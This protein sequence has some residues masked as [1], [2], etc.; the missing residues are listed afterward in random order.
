M[1][2]RRSFL[3]TLPTTFFVLLFGLSA[4]F[5][6]LTSYDPTLLGDTPLAA[7]VSIGLFLAA[8]YLMR[9]QGLAQ[10]ISLILIALCVGLAILF[11][12]Q[13]RYQEYPEMAGVIQRLGDATTLLPNLGLGYLHPNAV[14]TVLEVALP[15]ALA[16]TLSIRRTTLR[17]VCA[18]VVLLFLYAI[19]LTYSRGAYI[20]LGGAIV[21]LVLKRLARPV[22]WVVMFALALIAIGGVIALYNV[23]PAE[24]LPIL[25]RPVDAR[26]TLYHNSLYLAQD[27]AFSGIGLGS[28]FGN[29]YSRYSLLIQ[30]VFLTY[31]HNLLLSVWLNQGLLGL[32]AFL[33]IIITFYSYVAHIIGRGRPGVLFHGLWL[34]VTATLVHGLFDARQYTE[35]VWVMPVLFIALGLTIAYGQLT[36]AEDADVLSFRQ[37]I[38]LP[39]G[40]AAA[41]IAVLVVLLVIFRAPITAAWLTNQG[42]LRETRAEFT[43]DLNDDER[44]SL[45]D[46]A[47]AGYQD[48]L[49]TDPE[50]APANRR[51]GNLLVGRESFDE[52]VPL[53]ERAY[54]HEPTNPAAIKG[55]GLAYVWVGRTAEAAE[56]LKRLPNVQDMANELYTWGYFRS[57]G[58][59]QKPLL[60]AYAW[61]TAEMMGGAGNVD[62]WMQIGGFYEE[63]DAL[64][65][66]RA[67]YE[68]VIE[69]DPNNEAAQAALDNL[70]DS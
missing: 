13:F 23:N 26:L 21:V 64:D 3:P 20:G 36:P 24:P 53:L 31:S 10:A 69:L 38:R 43:P 16:F 28:T 66:A 63:A 42:A 67:A 19:F 6:M 34:G 56:L 18:L 14:A 11:I 9:T 33:G 47:A 65:R 54:A 35:S 12:G 41:T 55:L 58:E 48:A 8:A 17:L 4:Y 27:Y 62:V 70:N 39:L 52:A 30:P 15:L 5:G 25:N 40:F 57:G 7:M 1:P 60:A 37:W 49:V 46:R 59:Q 50:Y 29:V 61:E 45:I 32:V 44:A 22:T 2:L 51:L 68:H